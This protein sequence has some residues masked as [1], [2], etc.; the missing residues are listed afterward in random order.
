VSGFGTFGASFLSPEQAG[1]DLWTGGSFGPEGGLLAPAA[2]LL[3]VLL[4][5][6]WVRLRKGKISLHLSI[7]E[8]PADSSV[9]RTS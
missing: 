4:T 6:L 9:G 8:G 1:P 2:M 5:A 7:A 3:G